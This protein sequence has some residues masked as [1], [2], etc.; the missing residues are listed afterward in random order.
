MEKMQLSN[1][2]TKSTIFKYLHLNKVVMVAQ[3]TLK[4]TTFNTKTFFIRQV[5]SEKN[6]LVYEDKIIT[7]D[8]EN[9]KIS[10]SFF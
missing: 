9:A 3:K 2:P 7:N 8:D 1:I 4:K 10:N 6:T 5:K